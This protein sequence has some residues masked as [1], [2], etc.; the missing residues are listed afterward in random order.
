[1]TMTMTMTMTMAMTMPM[2]S[3]PTPT[4]TPVPAPGVA[5]AR[6]GA[7]ASTV[8]ASACATLLDGF[9]TGEDEDEAL[10][11]AARRKGVDHDDALV[12]PVA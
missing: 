6:G 7:L 1:M 2:R 9:P 8:L 4:D 10:L 12:M 11:D 5:G 3:A